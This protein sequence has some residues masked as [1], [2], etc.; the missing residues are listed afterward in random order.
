MR[1]SDIVIEQ[2]VVESTRGFIQRVD[3]ATLKHW[4]VRN[5]SVQPVLLAINTTLSQCLDEDKERVAGEFTVQACSNQVRCDQEEQNRD[6]TLAAADIHLAERLQ[7][8]LRNNQIQIDSDQQV[9]HG[10]R[11]HLGLMENRIATLNLDIIQRSGLHNDHHHDEHHH[12]HGHGFSP[13][14]V[15]VEIEYLS[16]LN[17]ER[18]MLLREASVLQGQVRDKQNEVDSCLKR[19]RDITRNLNVTL[20]D[21]Q[22]SRE[23]RARARDE[24]DR[25]RQNQDF[26]LYQLS[27]EN[28]A[29]LTMQIR[30]EHGQLKTLHDQL[31]RQAIETSYAIYKQQLEL[32]LANH[33]ALPNLNLNQRETLTQVLNNMNEHLAFKERERRGRAAF[34]L[35]KRSLDNQILALQR[36]ELQVEEL[37]RSN[38]DLLNRNIQLESINAQL[39]E[40]VVARTSKGRRLLIAGLAVAMGSAALVG[41]G[42]LV[43]VTTS[44]AV[45][46]IPTLFIPAAIACVVMLGLLI[47]GAVMFYKN[48][49]D[50]NRHFAN[51]RQVSGN[52]LTV[53]NQMERMARLEKIEIPEVTN[54]IEESRT[55]IQRIQGEINYSVQMAALHLDK[56]QKMEDTPAY[57]LGADTSQLF[58]QQ[59]SAPPEFESAPDLLPSS[60]SSSSPSS[61]H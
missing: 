61:F 58:F 27:R 14:H 26:G 42:F 15:H 19:N 18:S 17:R 39:R 1:L 23:N 54:Q 25:A 60:P 10:H 13:V 9:L 22:A 29:N 5:E 4:V 3:F 44:I 21:N 56:A 28:R 34:D 40:A 38:P 12:H 20:P 31:Q 43:I 32:T 48:W 46:L 6:A 45:S 53:N 41:A 33:S 52:K 16:A 51:E 24:R 37:N 30:K 7:S 55:N 2:L 36:H 47:A 57:S 50:N 8:E 35:E 11:H 49:Q 59:A